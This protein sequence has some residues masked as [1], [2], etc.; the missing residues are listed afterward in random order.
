MHELALCRA[1]AQTAIDAAQGR[2]VKRVNVQVG[3]LR[4]VVPAALEQCWSMRVPGTVLDVCEL[5]VDYVPARVRC[6]SCEEVSELSVPVFACQACASNAVEV[7][8]GEEFVVLS[9]DLATEPQ[10]PKDH[11]TFPPP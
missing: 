5:H 11:G 1:I 10:E 4:Q 8:S 2:M 7:I 3:H 9:I 6:R